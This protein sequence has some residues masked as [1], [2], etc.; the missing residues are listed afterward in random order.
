VAALNRS[1]FAQP[2]QRE[3]WAQHRRVVDQLSERFSD[4]VQLL[5]KAAEDILAFAPLPEVALAADLVEQPS[6]AAQ[7]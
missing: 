4:G 1:I 5:E 3:V 7:S 6:G 2:N